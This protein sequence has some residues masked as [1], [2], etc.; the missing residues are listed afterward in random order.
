MLIII[1]AVVMSGGEDEAAAP[2]PAP[3]VAPPPPAPLP[4]PPPPPPPPP[5]DCDVTF[6]PCTAACEASQDR[7]ITVVTAQ[8]GE[9]ASD[10]PC[11]DS[12]CDDSATSSREPHHRRPVPLNAPFATPQAQGPRAIRRRHA[13]AVWMSARRWTS[14]K[15]LD[16]PSRSRSSQPRPAL[17][18]RLA[19]S[20]LSSRNAR[21]EVECSGLKGA[22]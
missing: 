13:P 8:F 4:A 19:P 11:D 10:S 2:A 21:V 18:I 9:L 5:S 22:A 20:R 3:Y 16:P 15:R 17:P 1:I 14:P 12:P 6:S 7:I